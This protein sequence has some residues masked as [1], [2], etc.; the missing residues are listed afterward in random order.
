VQTAPG[1]AKAVS[2]IQSATLRGQ[3]L[4]KKIMAFSQKP[5]GEI[6]PEDLGKVINSMLPLIQVAVGSSNKVVVECAKDLWK[7]RVDVGS[8]ENVLINLCINARDAMPDTGTLK[9]ALQNRALTESTHESK[10]SCTVGEYV[11]ISVCDTGVGIPDEIKD[12]IFDPFFTTKEVGQGTGLGLSTVQN[13][14]QQ[15]YG[16]VSVHSKVGEGTTFQ[17]F[18]PRYQETTA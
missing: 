2:G 7:T 5:G 17:I 1:A 11:L 8:F 4:I 12:Q 9:I 13:F 15:S 16:C 18:L 14:V 6:Q 3:A 10:E